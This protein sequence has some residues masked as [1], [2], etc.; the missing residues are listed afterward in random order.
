MASVGAMIRMVEGLTAKDVG[1]WDLKFI[2][3]VVEKSEGGKNT[4]HITE[5]QI[6]HIER[7][8]NKHFA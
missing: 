4:R 2:A 7:I 6:V 1:E 5:K 8:F 3:S